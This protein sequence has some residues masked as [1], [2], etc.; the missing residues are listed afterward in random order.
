MFPLTIVIGI[1]MSLKRPLV[2][3][4]GAGN[5]A[6]LAGHSDP[7]SH[8]RST[9]GGA[10]TTEC[11]EGSESWLPLLWRRGSAAGLL[12]HAVVKIPSVADIWFIEALRAKAENRDI[13]GCIGCPLLPVVFLAK[14]LE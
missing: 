3:L 4:G 6:Y 10:R 14:S 7:P 9:R 5:P 2:A 11:G 1:S 13:A 8:P 12:G